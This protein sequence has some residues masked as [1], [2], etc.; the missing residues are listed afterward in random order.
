MVVLIT[1]VTRK[2]AP[3]FGHLNFEFRNYL[4]FG[5]CDLKLA[6]LELCRKESWQCYTGENENQEKIH[7]FVI[8]A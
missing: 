4:L 1:I 5:A 3:G 8:S 6:N 7:K 2:V